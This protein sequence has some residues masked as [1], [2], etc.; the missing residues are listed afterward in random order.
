MCLFGTG[1]RANACRFFSSV[2]LQPES[3]PAIM[4]EIFELINTDNI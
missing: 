2:F 1:R 4:A 3:V